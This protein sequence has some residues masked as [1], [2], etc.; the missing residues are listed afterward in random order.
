MKKIMFSLILFF[1]SILFCQ[2]FTDI[3]PVLAGVSNSSVAWGDYDNDG[4]L[5]ILL[6][7]VDETWTAVSKIYRNDS[8]VFTDLNAGLP[9]VMDGSAAWGDF[10]ND[11]DLDI[12]LTGYTGMENIS[13]IYRNDSGVFTDINAGLPETLDGFTVWS[14]YDN[15]GDLDILLTGFIYDGTA[16]NIAS[17]YR[18]DNGIFTDINAG[19]TGVV[20]GSAAWGD[21]DNDG[22][23]DL[24]LTGDSDFGP[25]SIIYNNMSGVFTDINA[26]LPGVIDGSAAWGDY[27]NDGDLDIVLT[28]DTSKLKISKIYNNDSGIFIDINAGLTG[29]YYSSVAWGDYDNDGDLDIVLTGDTRTLK[30]SKIYNNDSGIF[31][32]INAGL[33][34]VYYSS[35]AWGDFD[36]DGDLDILLTG[37]TG[38]SIISKIYMNNSPVPNTIPSSPLNLSADINGSNITF[39][40]DRSTDNETPQNGLSYNVY[41]GTLSQNCDI[42]SPMSNIQTGYRKIVCSGNANQVNSYQIKIMLPG[43]YY[44]SV[45]AVDNNFSGS[46]FSTEQ[47]FVLSIDPPPATVA[48]EATDVDIYS[49]TANWVT[50]LDT[51]GYYLDV[52]TDS[53]FTNY[54]SG[55]QNRDVNNVTSFNVTGLSS[56]TDHYYRVRAYNYGGVGINSNTISVKTLYTQFIQVSA[57]LINAYHGSAVWGDYDNDG[58]LDFIITGNTGSAGSA[59]I[60][61]N[62]SGVFTDINA[63]LSGVYYSSAAWGDY[64]NDGDLDLVVTGFSDGLRISKIYRNDSGTFTDINAG[65]TGVIYSTVAW[66]DYDNDG[67]LDIL[68]T[69]SDTGLTCISKIYRNESGIF[70]DINAGLPGVYISTADWGDYDNDGDLDIL[71][72]GNTGIVSVSDIYRNDSG[73]FTGISAGFPAVYYGAIDWGD[74]DND[75]DLDLVYTGDTRTLDISRIYRND[76]GIFTDI[77]AGLTAVDYSSAAWGDF[78][79]DGDLDLLCT[80]YTGSAGSATIY[81]NDSGIFTDINAGLTEV[82]KSSAAWGDYDNDGDLDILMNGDTGSGYLTQIYKNISSIPNTTPS[83]PSN[84]SAVQ[85][86]STVTL[87]WDKATD[88]ETPQNGLSYNLYIRSDSLYVKSPMSNDSTGCRKIVNIGNINMRNSWTI[89]NLPQGMYYWSVQAVD[90]AFAGSVFA[91]EKS[92]V[93]GTLAVPSNV[94]ISELTGNV[95]VSWDAVQYADSYKIYASEDPYGTFDDVS[96]FG[97]F[98]GTSWSQPVGETKLFYYVVAVVE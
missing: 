74:Y 44:W 33:T 63:G 64:D 20:N 34:G 51:E 55:Y 39:S 24:L 8:G 2:A 40:W 38:S 50:T 89:K 54:V 5:D 32:D 81:R 76:S 97:T 96:E 37:Y 59:A 78:D 68:L 93:A 49:F 19:L 12:L 65:L 73:V 23:L 66:G 6:T 21:Y 46:E 42:K 14:D 29:V 61:R 72:S 26:G 4:D 95:T 10:D 53:S 70:T 28:G 86:D 25:V 83:P 36:N 85:A 82:Y 98:D 7:G 62:D 9:G 48:T 17:I 13:Q 88:T 67:D 60:Y 18:N 90:N 30:I 22:D 11:G 91:T 15:D 71:L 31:I 69:G 84:L 1:A 35:V 3:G 52:A 41:I 58:D 87:S 57:N 75:G 27:D 79:C 43:T 16:Y 47:S 77:N 92:F 80:G 45:Q 94:S 56:F